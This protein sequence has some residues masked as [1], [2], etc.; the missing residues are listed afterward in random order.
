MTV[1]DGRA[2]PAPTPSRSWS[3]RTG[4]QA[5]VVR[6]TRR[7]RKRGG[8]AGGRSSARH[9]LDPDGDAR[10]IFYLWDFGDGGANAF[11]RDAQ[12][13]YRTRAPTRRRSRRPTAAA[14]STPTRSSIEVET[15]RAT[16]P[17]TV[18]AAATPRSGAAPLRVS[19]SSQSGDPDGDQLDARCGTSATAARRGRSRTVSHTYTQPGHLHGD[20]DRERRRALTDTDSVQITVTDHG[21]RRRRLAAAGSACRASSGPGRRSGRRR[22]KKVRS[23]IRRGLRLGSAA[24]RPAAR[25]PCCGSRASGSARP[26]G[27]G[28]APAARARWWSGS[29][30]TCAGTCWRRC[31]RPA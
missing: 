9:A 13:T 19:F 8:A 17:P 1:T 2:R 11:G 24:R 14:R 30:A 6:A 18:Q 3:P 16:M 26:S 25:S 29:A 12:H 27:C 15:R 20:G 7:P 23:V 21:A 10:D 22:S 31:V 5:P 28:S 4:N